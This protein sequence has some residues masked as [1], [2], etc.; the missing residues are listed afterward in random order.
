MIVAGRSVMVNDNM[1]CSLAGV[2]KP[3]QWKVRE[4]RL[5]FIPQKLQ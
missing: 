3:A 2:E 5:P 4:R 1:R